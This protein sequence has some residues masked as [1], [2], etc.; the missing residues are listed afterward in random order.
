MLRNMQ[1][2]FIRQPESRSS[3]LFSYICKP[4]NNDTMKY[5]LFIFDLD[6]TLMDTSPGIFGSVRYA[7]SKMGFPPT[8]E[9]N[10]RHFVGPPPKDIYMRTYGIDEATAM[11]AVKYHREYGRARAVFEATVYPGMEETLAALKKMGAKVSV[12]TLKAQDMADSILHNFNLTPYFDH[13]V[14]MD[15]GES[16]TKCGAIQKTL[17]HAR[18][19]AGKA[20]MIGDSEYDWVGAKEA[21]VDFVGALYG[22]GFTPDS[23]CSEWIGAIGRAKDLVDVVTRVG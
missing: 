10:L 1:Y 6:G 3:N 18:V 2:P 4:Q 16:M 21:G 7:E 9:E 13:I 5:D 14:G 20:L 11:E 19:A 15:K 17:R 23:Y 8:A 12:A 22:F